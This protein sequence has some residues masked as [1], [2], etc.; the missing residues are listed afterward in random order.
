MVVGDHAAVG[1]GA[2][3][4]QRH[5][6]ERRSV[7]PSPNVSS[8]SGTGARDRVDGL[9]RVGDDD[10]ALGGRGDDLLA[11][12][13]AAAALDE[14]AVGRDLV[15][16]VDRDVEPVEALERLDRDPELAPAAAS[17]RGDVATQ[18]ISS[19]RAASAGSRKATVEPVPRPTVIPSATSS[20][21]ASA[22]ARFSA[23]VSAAAM[24]G[25]QSKRNRVFGPDG[26][27]RRE[28]RRW[29]HR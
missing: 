20:A 4:A 26:V 25:I 15:G 23:S 7:A 29:M 27:G 5:V 13:R 1:R 18:R 28:L 8:S 16:A 21:A 9:G 2:G 19:S 3:V 17:V 12:V 10:E 11:R 14:P 24:P 22:A 6:A